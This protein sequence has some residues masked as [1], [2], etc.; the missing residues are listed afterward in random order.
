MRERIQ[1]FT[2]ILYHNASRKDDS[3]KVTSKDLDAWIDELKELRRE[4]IRL[5]QEGID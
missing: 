5:E 2:A 3:Y 1:R 4:L